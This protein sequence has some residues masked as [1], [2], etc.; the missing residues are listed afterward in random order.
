MKKLTQVTKKILW[1]FMFLF[2]SR[3][4]KI[5]YTRFF[6][7]NLIFNV[8]HDNIKNIEV[9][10]HK[11]FESLIYMGLLTDVGNGEYKKCENFNFKLIKLLLF[12]GTGK[13][14]IR[15]DIRKEM[16]NRIEQIQFD[17]CYELFGKED[18]FKSLL[19]SKD[20]ELLHSIDGCLRDQ[21]VLRYL[22]Y[23]PNRSSYKWIKFPTPTKILEFLKEDLSEHMLETVNF[24]I[25][26]ITEYFSNELEFHNND[27]HPELLSKPTGEQ[28]K[29]KTEEHPE[30]STIDIV[31][32]VS[33]ISLEVKMVVKKIHNIKTESQI[34]KPF[35][36]SPKCIYA[37]EENGKVGIKNLSSVICIEGDCFSE[38]ELVEKLKI[39][40]EGINSLNKYI[41]LQKEKGGPRTITFKNVY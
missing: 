39:I 37:F 31:S 21:I 2:P 40:D 17:P 13:K 27:L 41:Q 3:F 26:M 9:T 1:Q 15:R 30:N 29:P 38:E 16:L 28:E 36:V 18:L 7:N 32:E 5:L 11:A 19:P 34:P 8:N 12:E 23:K 4:D 10:V 24:Y 20:P 33:P 35:L 6:Q 14:S 25:E 22:L